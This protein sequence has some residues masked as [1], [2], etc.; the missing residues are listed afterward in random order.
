METEMQS[1]VHPFFQ[2][3]LFATFVGWILGIVVLI[4]LD[5]GAEQIGIGNQFPLVSV[6]G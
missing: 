6:W 4:L 3:W 1:P 2:R 5:E